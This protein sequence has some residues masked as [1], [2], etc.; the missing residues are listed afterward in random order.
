MALAMARI[1]AHF[2]INKS[3]LEHDQIIKNA[4]RLKDIPGTIVHGRY[5]MVCP[6]NQAFALSNAWPSAKLE[7]IADAGHSSGEPGI[8]D[9]LIRATNKLAFQLEKTTE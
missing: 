1:E 6:V 9:A 4:H 2:F 5:D 8:T 3:F 7:I